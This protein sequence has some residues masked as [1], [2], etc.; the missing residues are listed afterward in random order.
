MYDTQRLVEI[1]NEI[2]FTAR[3]RG[4]FDSDID[5]IRAIEREDRTGRA[6]IVEGRKR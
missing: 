6:V 3:S 5:D 1:L 4:A 2:G